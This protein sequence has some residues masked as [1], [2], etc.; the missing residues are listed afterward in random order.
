M[1]STDHKAYSNPNHNLKR[2]AEVY[3]RAQFY[4]KFYDNN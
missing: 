4:S 1:T 3:T 2:S